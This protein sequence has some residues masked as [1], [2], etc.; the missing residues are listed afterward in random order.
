MDRC[1]CIAESLC[2]TPEANTKLKIN[3]TPIKKKKK[4]WL[5]VTFRFAHEIYFNTYTCL[6]NTTII[7]FLRAFLFLSTWMNMQN[8]KSTGEIRTEGKTLKDEHI[9][10]KT[11]IKEDWGV[12]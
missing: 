11:L 8:M 7:Y 9:A 10:Q 5:S 4:I 6:V 12:H 3:Y 1:I 2:C